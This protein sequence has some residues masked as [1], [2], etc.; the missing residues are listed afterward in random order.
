MK[1]FEICVFKVLYFLKMCQIFVAS[2]NNFGNKQEKNKG[3]CLING[4]SYTQDLNFK[5][6]SN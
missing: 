2:V 6:R 4:Q 5:N 1:N 3:V